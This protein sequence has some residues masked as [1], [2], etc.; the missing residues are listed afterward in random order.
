MSTNS[1]ALSN[2]SMPRFF[3]H[4]EGLAILAASLFAYS[5]MEFGW[6]SFALFLL[7]PDLI[8]VF[9]LVNKRTGSVAYNVVHSIVLPLILAIYSITSD[10][11]LG[12][13]TSLIWFAHIGMDHIF[14]YGFKYIGEFK[15]THFSRI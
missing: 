11:S 15:E 1:P 8:A 5:K 9:Y 10:N 13:Q 2:I 14:G 12:I 7:A 3:L 6:G 4:L